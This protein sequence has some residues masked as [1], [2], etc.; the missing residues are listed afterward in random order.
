[1]QRTIG[2]TLSV[3]I[4]ATLAHSTDTSFVLHKRVNEVQ[5]TVVATD[6]AGRPWRQLSPSEL[7]IADDGQS[8]P[9][10]QVRAGSDLPL[11]VGIVLDSSDSMRRAWPAVRSA[12]STSLKDLVRPGDQVLM[13]TFSN[14][15]ESESAAKLLSDLLP[16]AG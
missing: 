5:F 12:L 3:L 6:S 15:I 8:I 2:C 10:F 16:G 4:L 13:V 9:D 1:M 7:T 11:R 14:R